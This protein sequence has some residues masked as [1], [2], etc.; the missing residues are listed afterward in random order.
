[1]RRA[2]FS[3]RDARHFP[4]PRAY[5]VGWASEDPL[6]VPPD[7]QQGARRLG[8]A[9]LFRRFDL[10]D[11]AAGQA[12]VS[13]VAG[14]FARWRESRMA[15]SRGPDRVERS[16]ALE[17]LTELWRE[18]LFAPDELDAT[19]RTSPLL[20]RAGLAGDL[21]G[22]LRRLLRRVEARDS[23]ALEKPR[24]TLVPPRASEADPGA[25][26]RARIQLIDAATRARQSELPALVA[27]NASW[28]GSSQESL[29]EQ[30]LAELLS[31]ATLARTE[32][33]R[34]ELA[35]RLDPA[36]LHVKTACYILRLKADLSIAES[37]QLLHSAGFRAREGRPFSRNSVSACASMARKALEAAEA[38]RRTP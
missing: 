36:R 7:V 15:R 25:V 35:S 26:E 14:A 24:L 28:L 2:D 19:R 13:L 4:M 17:A 8:L 29:D 31:V 37:H 23:S 16:S 5:T 27:L 1:M 33:L 9:G 30:E 12:V 18:I 32:N 6:A 20:N 21:V 22:E 11:A 38:S 3:L 10:G 34:Q